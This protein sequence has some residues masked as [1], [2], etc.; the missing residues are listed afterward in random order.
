MKRTLPCLLS[1]VVFGV[2]CS[3]Q[4]SKPS[5]EV[6]YTCVAGQNEQC[7]SDL[8]YADYLKWKAI[9]DKYKMP[10]E[11]AD[12]ANGM[13]VRLNQQIPLGYEWS[14]PKQRF[15]KKVMGLPAPQLQPTAP[16]AK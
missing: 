5:A 8:W 14:D 9:Y 11:E 3:K 15:V 4:S 13:A 16:P 12:K 6:K 1:L 10:T 7:A 2:A